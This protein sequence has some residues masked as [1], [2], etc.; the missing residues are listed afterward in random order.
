MRSIQEIGIELKKYR[1]DNKIEL[2]KLLKDMKISRN[3]INLVEKGEYK[4]SNVKNRMIYK[5]YIEKLGLDYNDY[6]EDIKRIFPNVVEETINLSQSE[7]QND[8]K[9]KKKF[10]INFGLLSVIII[11]FFL[12]IAIP[13]T[14][15][16]FNNSISDDA[17]VNETTTL[18]NTVLEPITIIEPE[19][20]EL[21][22][23]RKSPNEVEVYVEELD[24]IVVK[25][26]ASNNAYYS[27]D[28]KNSFGGYTAQEEGM[29]KSEDEK[30]LN[31][32]DGED[33]RVNIGNLEN[34]KIYV[35]DSEITES[36]EEKGIQNFITF[37]KAKE[38]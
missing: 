19:V 37:K 25:I 16:N 33:A 12:I 23:K 10:K 27:Y 14:I 17:V 5:K 38:E 22:V 36:L 9:V 24:N 21:E 3:T 13:F 34:V 11:V 15:Y 2:D 26:E 7:I 18:S 29:L 35:N 8:I 6:E 4:V 28:L 32:E 31:I 1:I 20:K 30:T